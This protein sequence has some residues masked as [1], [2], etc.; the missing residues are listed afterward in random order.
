MFADSPDVS[1]PHVVT[2][3]SNILLLDLLYGLLYSVHTIGTA[4]PKDIRN[5]CVFLS[6]LTQMLQAEVFISL[7][8]C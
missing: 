1:Y 5:A 8:Y 2:K 6:S 4:F 3:A 7:Y